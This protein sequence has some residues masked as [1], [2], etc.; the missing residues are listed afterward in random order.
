M[1]NAL[2]GVVSVIRIVFKSIFEILVNEITARAEGLIR[3]KHHDI[4]AS[5]YQVMRCLDSQFEYTKSQVGHHLNQQKANC[6]QP[7]PFIL[8]HRT[9]Q[10]S[11]KSETREHVE[12]TKSMVLPP[13]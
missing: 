6:Q 4:S 7:D 3:G 10:L 13:M 11:Q 5:S 1:A 8:F 12:S 9:T 2:H